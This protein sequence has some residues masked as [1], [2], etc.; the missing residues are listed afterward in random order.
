MAN[1]QPIVSWIITGCQRA[2]LAP[3]GLGA[4]IYAAADAGEL[5]EEEASL[6]VRSFLTA[7]LDTTVVAAQQYASGSRPPADE[8]PAGL[9]GAA[10]CARSAVRYHFAATR[11]RERPQD[12]ELLYGGSD[13][14][15]PVQTSPYALRFRAPLATSTL[16]TVIVGIA[17]NIPAGPNRMAAPTTPIT[18]TSG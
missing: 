8:G 14:H 10:D 3:G 1:A 5:T 4:Q 2:A 6:L 12:A 13:L 9:T 17:R 18:T 7:G 16:T 11:A 15:L